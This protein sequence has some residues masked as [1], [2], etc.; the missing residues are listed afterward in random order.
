MAFVQLYPD[1]GVAAML[2]NEWKDRSFGI[3]AIN[4]RGACSDEDE[5]LIIAAADPQGNLK[6]L[7]IESDTSSSVTANIAVL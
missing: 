2:R 6:G 1:M 5:L 4:E 3:A 7:H